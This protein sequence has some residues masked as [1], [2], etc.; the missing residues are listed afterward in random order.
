[1][2]IQNKHFIHSVL[3]GLRTV[4]IALGLILFLTIGSSMVSQADDRQFVVGQAMQ[5]SR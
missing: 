3:F 2:N 5:T 4:F 1:M